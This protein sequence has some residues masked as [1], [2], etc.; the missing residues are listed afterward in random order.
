MAARRTINSSVN[1]IQFA[2][3]DDRV[4]NDPDVAADVPWTGRAKCIVDGGRGKVTRTLRSPGSLDSCSGQNLLHDVRRFD[5]GEPLF[6]ALEFV[7]QSGVVKPEQ[8]QNR[9]VQVVDVDPAG[10]GISPRLIR[11]DGRHYRS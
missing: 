5:A 2:S 6:E 1:D 11:C 7:R 8:M 4:G 3:K 10:R 9:R